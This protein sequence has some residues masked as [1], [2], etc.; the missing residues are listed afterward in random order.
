MEKKSIGRKIFR[1]VREIIKIVLILAV[2]GFIGIF[3][4]VGERAGSS[5]RFAEKYFTYYITNN[6]QEMYKMI[7]GENS[8]FISFE[9]FQSMCSGEKVYGSMKDY[10]IGSATKN[11]DSVTYVVSYYMEGDNN[12][13]TYTITL[14]KQKEK[15]YL[16]FD[17]WKVSVKRFLVK[18][19]QIKTPAGM[20][21]SLD[22][23]D[24][25]KYSD[26]TSEDGTQDYYRIPVL[27]TGDHTLMVS[28]DIVGNI[29]K[30][31]Y[32]RKDDESMELT[33]KDFKMN[34]G[35]QKDIESYSGLLLMNMYT[36]TMDGVSTFEDK[37]SKLFAP[38]EQSQAAA[39]Y[40]FDQLRAAITKEDGSSLRTLDIGTITPYLTTFEYPG[41]AVVQVDYSYSFTANGGT[42]ILNG[43]INYYSGDGW[44]SARYTFTLAD[45]AWKVTG[46]EM[47]CVNYE[48]S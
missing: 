8:D 40:A 47:P 16:F 38:D 48:E 32:V 31:V 6:Y 41:K 5:Y 19:F 15:K 45:G 42:T 18:D 39:R 25:S 21:A 43:I 24:L 34:S 23:K 3:I 33:T 46:I 1:V 12:Q 28:S 9:N 13:H 10:T 35:E 44:A 22:G 2:C 14:N 20:K 36:Y 7:D 27:F 4:A 30:A 29:S 17:T 37:V 26:G 11:G